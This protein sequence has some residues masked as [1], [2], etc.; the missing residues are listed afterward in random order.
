[1]GSACVRNTHRA[2]AHR[3]QVPRDRH[4]GGTSG[5]A[6]GHHA[7]I[8]GVI[9]RRSSR[10]ERYHPQ[11]AALH[12]L[13]RVPADPSQPGWGGRFV[14][15]WDGRKTIFDR[16]TTA[17]DRPSA[18]HPN[19]WIDDQDPAAA[20]RVHAGAKNVSRWREEF[21]RDFARR[22][23]RT[24]GYHSRDAFPVSVGR[25][26]VWPAASWSSPRSLLRPPA[27]IRHSRAGVFTRRQAP[28]RL[29]ARRAVDDESGRA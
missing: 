9:L 22:M 15:I 8:Q 27:P 10:T 3:I 25:A 19:W 21:L 2:R 4:R 1:M 6:R 24:T 20:E 23:T 18:R 13:H 5:V 12:L 14:R 16:L 11:H 17:A 26:T 29:V 7:R 28:R